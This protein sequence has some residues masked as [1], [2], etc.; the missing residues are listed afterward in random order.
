MYLEVKDLTVIYDRATVLNGV[1]FRVNDGELVGIVGPNGAGKTTTLRAVAGLIKWEI[2]TL[3]GTSIGKI[4]FRGSVILDGE[5]IFGFPS[6]I[7]AQR[8]LSLCPERGRPLREMRVRENLDMGAYLIKDRKEVME[9]RE[10]VYKLFPILQKRE[11]QVAGTLSGGERAMLAIGRSFMAQAKLMLIDEPSVGLAPLAK[12]ELFGGIKGVHELGIT[13]LLVEQDVG[14]TF[15]LSNRNYIL[16]RGRMI[17][18]GK[19]EELLADE[20]IRKTYLGL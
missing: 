13:V 12:E 9:H 16:S 10:K 6:H 15:E 11:K 3:K 4:T 8:G 1:S 18:E 7:I 17:G 20:L 19:K 2:D 14:F 5:N